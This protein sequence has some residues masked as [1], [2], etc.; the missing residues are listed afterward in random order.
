MARASG[1]LDMT[2]RLLAL[3]HVFLVW[4]GFWVKNHG[5]YPTHELLR[6]K[7]YDQCPFVALVRSGFFDRPGQ[8]WMSP[9][10]QDN[11]CVGD[12]SLNAIS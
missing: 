4:D 3:G 7:N 2:S 5:L 9:L 1:L 12:S 10:L 6:V 11:G 8:V